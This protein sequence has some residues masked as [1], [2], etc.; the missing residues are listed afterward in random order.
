MDGWVLGIWD[1]HTVCFW[2]YW[3]AFLNGFQFPSPPFFWFGGILG[4][5]SRAEFPASLSNHVGFK[6][7]LLHSCTHHS[8]ESFTH[9]KTGWAQDA[10]LQWSHEN[11]SRWPTS[12]TPMSWKLTC[13]TLEQLA[14]LSSVYELLAVAQKNKGVSICLTGQCWKS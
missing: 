11:I 10:W 8:P 5:A 6:P 13:Q 4:S 12:I 3:L 9:L 1:W 14:L 2:W 7:R